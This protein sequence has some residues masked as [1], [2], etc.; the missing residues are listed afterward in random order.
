MAERLT[1]RVM[2]RRQT[3]F[4]AALLALVT[5]LN[6]D[7]LLITQVGNTTVG[8][9]RLSDRERLGLRGPVKTCSDFFRDDAE[10]TRDVEYAAD[11]RLLVWRDNLLTGKV[12][13]VYSYDRMGKLISVT[14]SGADVTDEFHY[15]E[16]G[17]K[18]ESEPF[19]CVPL[20]GARGRPGH[21]FSKTPKKATASL[22]VEASPRSTMT[23]TN[24][25]SLWSVTP[26]GNCWE[27]SST[28]IRTGDLSAKHLS[29]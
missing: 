9:V 13:R 8:S 10:P 19:P 23:K 15:D 17:K 11:G 16:Q 12:E 22:A 20:T 29:G 27:K 25:S 2:N 26:M 18:T 14:S 1:R 7:C 24:Q 5:L 3:L 28:T 4:R 21:S 6:F